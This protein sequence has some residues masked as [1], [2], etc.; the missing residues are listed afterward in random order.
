MSNLIDE[1][2]SARE[3]LR[4]QEA[5]TSEAGHTLAVCKDRQRKARKEL[6]KLLDELETGVSRYP[7]LG[8]DRLEIPGANGSGTSDEHQR[9]PTE[10]PPAARIAVEEGRPARA[11]APK[12]PV[13]IAPGKPRRKAK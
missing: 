13:S 2:R 1:I 6:D 7:L 8:F 5:E 10:F 4:R 9:G 3:E 11:P 12:S